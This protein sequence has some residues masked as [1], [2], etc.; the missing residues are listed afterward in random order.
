MSE[1]RFCDIT[2]LNGE[3]IQ[4][5]KA[6]VSVSDRG[7]MFGDG[8][9]EV[10]PVFNGKLFRLTPHIERLLQS[11]DAIQLPSPLSPDEWETVLH[12][13][14][15]KNGSANQAV[16]VQI[17]RGPTQIRRH[18]FPKKITPTYFAMSMPLP[19]PSLDELRQGYHA[20]TLPDCRWSRCSIKAIT[21]LPNILMGQQAKDA[22]CDE[23][24][25]IRD[26]FVT[27]GTSCNVFIV[28]NKTIITPPKT[29]LLLGGITRDLVIELAHLHSMPLKEEPIDENR[30]AAADEIWLTSSGREIRPVILLNDKPVGN[31]KPGVMWETII[32][33]YQAYKQ[34]L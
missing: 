26:G 14:V 25:L 20:I 4:T 33:H 30:L 32:S 13:L 6:V 12:E 1:L 8:I 23:A 27:E 7:F 3:F 5:D 28:E 16:Y 22:G 9:Y 18:L 15:I 24:I 2:Y 10:V 19:A 31:G 11:L 34:S 21:L 17:T 29:P